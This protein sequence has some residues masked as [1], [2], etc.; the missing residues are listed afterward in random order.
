MAERGGTA[1][2]IL[3]YHGLSDARRRKGL[4]ATRLSSRAGAPPVG[5]AFTLADINGFQPIRAKWNG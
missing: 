5:V 4:L 1:D 2:A 3:P